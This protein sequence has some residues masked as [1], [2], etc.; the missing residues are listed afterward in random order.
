VWWQVGAGV[1]FALFTGGL[2]ALMVAINYQPPTTG[3]LT[4]LINEFS[5]IRYL[6]PVTLFFLGGIFG[7]K[8]YFV[9]QRQNH[10]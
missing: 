4:V 2:Y 7:I 5:W 10:Y 6:M 1:T 8:T 9:Y 3:N